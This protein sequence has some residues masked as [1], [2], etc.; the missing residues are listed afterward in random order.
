MSSPSDSDR[1]VTH[2]A[3]D[4]PPPGGVDGAGE[5]PE[6]LSDFAGLVASRTGW[7]Q[8]VLRP[9]C[10]RAVRKDL[11]LAEQEWFDIAGKVDPGKTLWNWAWSRFPPLVHDD[12]GIDESQPVSVTL[13][14]G[15]THH[16]YPD[17][18]QSSRGQL[19]LVGPRPAGG[20]GDLGPF[21]IDDI[22][23]VTT[24]DSSPSIS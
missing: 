5:K 23:T 21:S 19:V 4:L 22:L 15:S 11:L 18:R 2:A 3:D 16:G 14:D 10:Q 24:D 13:C 7:I 17:A 12:L 9:W 6:L 8:Q 1:F 20:I